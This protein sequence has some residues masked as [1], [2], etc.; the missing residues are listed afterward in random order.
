VEIAASPRFVAAPDW[1]HAI[2]AD[3]LVQFGAGL[4]QN[5][6]QTIERFLALEAMGSNQAQDQLR[7]LK[8]RVFER[9]EPTAQ[10]LE[11][12]LR[13]LASGDFRARLAQLAVPSLWIAGRNDRLIPPA[14]MRWASEQCGQG[15][16]VEI[17][18]G[19]APFLGHAPTV[20]QAIVEFARNTVPA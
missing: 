1:P 4:R 13:L 7:E 8:A 5:Y 12:G 16:F 9:G 10:A 3:V 15:R 18:S 2:D 11:D 17:P 6:R 14:A 20:A 19:H